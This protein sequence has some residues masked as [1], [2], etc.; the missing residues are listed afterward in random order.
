MVLN[1]YFE[2][3]GD[4]IEFLIALG[5]VIGLLGIIISILG[6][7][8]LSKYY[9]T[10]V[11]LVLLASIILICLCGLNTGLIYFGLY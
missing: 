6:L 4:G 10:K 1:N 8:V 3:L 5:S 9:K 7:I 2:T 11:L